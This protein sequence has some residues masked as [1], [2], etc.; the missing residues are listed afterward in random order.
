MPPPTRHERGRL[1]ESL[2]AAALIARGYMLIE[3]N[4][5]CA[6]GEIDL[7]MREGGELVFVEV[8]STWDDAGRALE[9]ITAAKAIRLSALADAY[10]S[11]HGLDGAPFRIDV[12]AVCRRT[13]AVEVMRDAIVSGW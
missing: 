5:R 10:L 9:S 3:R 11:A 2:A 13:G 12:A 6:S 1:G 8:R 4:W 7:V